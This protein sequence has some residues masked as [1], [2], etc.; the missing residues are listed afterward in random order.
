MESHGCYLLLPLEVIEPN[1]QSLIAMFNCQRVGGLEPISLR[2]L[3]NLQMGSSLL[4]KKKHQLTHPAVS[5][6]GL[7]SDESLA[8]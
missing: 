5:R 3:S 1:G 8:L 7:T 6:S 4:K 2:G